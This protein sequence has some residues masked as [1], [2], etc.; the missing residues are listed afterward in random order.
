MTIAIV[1][2]SHDNVPNIEK[3]LIWANL[4]SIEMIIHCGDIAAPSMVDKFFAPKFPSQ[5]HL[6]YGKRSRVQSY[7]L[8]SGLHY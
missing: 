2:D 3:F 4:N 7:I 6:V 8:V 1:S 5:I